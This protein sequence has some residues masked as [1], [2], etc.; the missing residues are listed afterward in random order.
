MNSTAPDVS[1]LI[2]NWNGEHIL[3]RCLGSIYQHTQQVSFEIVLCDD[4]STDASLELVRRNFPQVKVL[5]NACNLG[6]AATTNRAMTLATGRYFLLLNNDAMFENNVLLEFVRFMDATPKAGICSGLLLNA[7]GSHQHSFGAFPSP[8]AALAEF[9]WLRRLF[10]FLPPTHL[11]TV[12][13]NLTRAYAVPMVVGTNLFIRASLA[14]ALSLYDEQFVA[15]F[16]DSDLCYRAWRAGWQVFFVPSARLTHLF[17]YSYGGKTPEKVKRQ[18]ER[19]LLG[20]SRFC[21]K[22]YSPAKAHLTLRLYRWLFFKTW[23]ML[24][25]KRHF[26]SKAR[27][28]ALELEIFRNR[29]GFYFLKNCDT[30]ISNSPMTVR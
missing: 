12:P 23:L 15:Y 27:Q 9:F 13:H 2:A 25:L 19:F 1:I 21:H 11:G 20:L 7:D 14:H 3:P 29:F 30:A 22:H 24:Q 8:F 4:A 18:M 26:V 28:P 16:E 5:S 17:S 10:P 6:Y